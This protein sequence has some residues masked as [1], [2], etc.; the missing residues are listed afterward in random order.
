MFDLSKKKKNQFTNKYFLYL[1]TSLLLQHSNLRPQTQDKEYENRF[2][3]T[4]RKKDR[5]GKQRVN[6]ESI[7]HQTI[8]H[9]ALRKEN[10]KIL[11]QDRNKF[12]H[13]FSIAKAQTR[14]H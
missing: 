8:W 7:D 4:P 1:L 12:N 2:D 13:V 6:N 3:E 11:K 10:V 14:S 9:T 5:T